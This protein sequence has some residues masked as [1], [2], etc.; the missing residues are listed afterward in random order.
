MPQQLKYN[1]KLLKLFEKKVLLPNNTRVCLEIIQHPGAA[2]IIPFFSSKKIVLLKQFRPVVNSYLYE[3]PAG[4]LDQNES[5]LSCAKREIVEETGYLAKKFNYL[6]YIYPV[7]GYSTEKIH[8]YK[9]DGLI[10]VGSKPEMDEVIESEII[11][12][13]KVKQLLKEG[14]IVDAK[15]ICAL[16]KCGWV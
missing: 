8:I 10:K 12:F 5:A 13:G 14:K 2:L 6:G 9:A 1:G 16:A 11:S 7:P 3:L 4:T 15:S